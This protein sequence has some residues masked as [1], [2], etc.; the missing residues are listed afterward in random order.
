MTRASLCTLAAVGW[1]ERSETHQF[2]LLARVSARRKWAT[3]FAMKG[4]PSRKGPT[5]APLRIFLSSTAEDLKAHRS[6]VSEAILRLEHL[7]VG[8]ES[9]GADPHD[10]V[11][12]CRRKVE[13]SDAVVV[14]VAHRYGWVPRPDGD[15]DGEKSITRIEVEAGLAAEKPVFAFL[16]DPKC[17]WDQP[18]EQD[19]LLEAK[20]AEEGEE[21]RKRVRGLGSFKAFLERDARITRDTFTTP[22]NL[23]SKVTA[24]LSK[25]VLSQVPPTPNVSGQEGP[26]E[27][28]A[29]PPRETRES[30]QELLRE[31]RVPSRNASSGRLQDQAPGPDRS[32]GPVRAPECDARPEGRG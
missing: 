22:D 9:F 15:G 26:T 4:S 24:S 12:V 13:E 21:V 6:R 14:I 23:E 10:P 8:M 19:R 28:V 20:T 3:G 1:V 25:W 7:P 11:S 17:S 29:F 18:R 31:S 32:R 27:H 16:V 5:R 30:R 2:G